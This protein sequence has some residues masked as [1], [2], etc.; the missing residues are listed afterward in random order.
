MPRITKRPNNLQDQARLENAIAQSYQN[1]AD[2]DYMSMVLD[3]ELEGEDD[4]TLEEI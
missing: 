1:R 4:G 2:I 3:V